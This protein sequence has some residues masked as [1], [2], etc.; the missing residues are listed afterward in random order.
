MFSASEQL[1]IS[2]QN[3]DVTAQD[4]NIA[5]NLAKAFYVRQRDLAA[6]QSFYRDVITNADDKKEPPR[7]SNIPRRCDDGS[8]QYRF[9][10]PEEYYRQQYFQVIESLPGELTRQFDQKGFCLTS[11]IEAIILNSCIG[12]A[13]QIPDKVSTLHSKDL[14][15]E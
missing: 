9:S 7:Y 11:K 15:L 13:C 2:L 12:Q 8:L 10:N 6:F 1:Y 14:N 3:K 5:V 4:A